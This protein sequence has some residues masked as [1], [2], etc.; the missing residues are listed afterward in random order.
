MITTSR[1]PTSGLK[2]SVWSQA[3][4]WQQRQD[5]QGRGGHQQAVVDLL[6]GE[7]LPRDPVEAF[8]VGE[9]Q[10]QGHAQSRR[11]RC[12]LLGEHPEQERDHQRHLGRHPRVLA[13][14]LQ[15]GR[16]R[17]QPDEDPGHDDDGGAAHTL[18]QAPQQ[19]DE[20]EGAD[21]G[22]RARWPLA[23]APLGLDPERQADAKRNS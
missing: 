14:A 23:L 18:R 2:A 11:Q 19:R 21:A 9:D 6:F 7:R 20:R 5:A 10:R 16:H 17:H 1:Q 13:L 3:L 4:V 15:V 12:V 22:R 8:A